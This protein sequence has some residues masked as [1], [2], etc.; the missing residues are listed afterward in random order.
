MVLIHL[1]KFEFNSEDFIN[2]IYYLN[3]KFFV[4][5]ET[6]ITNPFQSLINYVGQTINEDFFEIKIDV[7]LKNLQQ[8]IKNSNFS[9][10]LSQNQ[11]L[12]EFNGKLLQNLKK[13]DQNIQS[14][15]ELAQEILNKLLKLMIPLA[16]TLK[17]SNNRS[18]QEKS[19][20]VKQITIEKE[21]FALCP[22][23]IISIHLYIHEIS[24]L[25]NEMIK[26]KI[27]YNDRLI[28]KNI[29]CN[30]PIEIYEILNYGNGKNVIKIEIFQ[31]V[32]FLIIILS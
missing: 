4:K 28:E 32:T 6:N 30:I 10:I 8:Q 15:F 11:I 16:N 20:E 31:M 27:Q 5:K 23:T 12:Q 3:K 18:F 22:T 7:E 13:N 29:S 2:Q 21:L 24:L 14:D 9:E 19:S 25:T 1:G 17:A 26:V